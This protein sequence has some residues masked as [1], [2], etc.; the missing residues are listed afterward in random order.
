MGRVNLTVLTSL[1]L[2]VTKCAVECCKF[3][4]LIALELV[5]ALRNGRGLCIRLAFEKNM[6]EARN[7][8]MGQEI[9]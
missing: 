8:C 7:E 4:K 6:Q 5:L 9:H 1:V 2:V 3:S